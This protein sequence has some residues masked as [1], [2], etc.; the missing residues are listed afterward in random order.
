[1]FLLFSLLLLPIEP[2][3]TVADSPSTVE[4]ASPPVVVAG[5]CPSD[6]SCV[7]D[8]D[9][10][11]LL[12]IA[13]EHK[14]Q[15]DE[16]PKVDADPITIFVDREGRV[17]GSGSGPRPFTI[18][19]KWCKYEI[20]AKSNLQLQVAQRVEPTWGF[21]FRPKATFGVLGVEAFKV[22]KLYEALD[23][24]ILLEPFFY[25]LVNLNAYVGVR[26][27]GVGPGVD[28]TTN[29]GLFA[30]VVFTWGQWRTNPFLSAYFAF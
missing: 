2:A 5:T 19:L 29:F 4:V 25:H 27:F 10:Q 28:I 9:L 8:A 26:S 3:Q 22:N 15:S 16:L 30:G 24:G 11:V 13:K 1:M 7:S 18:H 12:Q 6:S 21:R 20:E 17:Y 14:C 23:G